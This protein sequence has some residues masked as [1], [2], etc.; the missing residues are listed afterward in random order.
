MAKWLLSLIVVGALLP[1][2]ASAENYAFL[3][4]VSDYDTKQ[5]RPLAYA[6]ADVLAFRD[7]LLDAG[8]D[9]DNVI[10][11]HDEHQ[12]QKD[13]NRRRSGLYQ[14]ET[15]AAGRNTNLH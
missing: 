13:R 4:G 11:L 3:V 10:T 14:K 9:A 6:R 12:A 8:L 2:R 7:V 15:E 5:L 1:G